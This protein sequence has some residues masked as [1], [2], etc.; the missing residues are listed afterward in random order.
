M[1]AAGLVMA[2]GNAGGLK[3]TVD[4]R[5]IPAIGKPAQVRRNIMLDREHLLK[6]T[7]E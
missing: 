7:G 2:T 6:N 5:E 4:G 1:V 3:I